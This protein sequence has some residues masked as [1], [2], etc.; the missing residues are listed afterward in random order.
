[1]SSA[2]PDWWK[3][4]GV[5]KLLDRLGAEGAALRAAVD[6]VI[7]SEKTKAAALTAQAVSLQ[8]TLDTT[9]ILADLRTAC[10]AVITALNAA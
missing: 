1:M 8:A 4:N 10:S 6:A 3:Q 9:P 5:D 7:A 2:A